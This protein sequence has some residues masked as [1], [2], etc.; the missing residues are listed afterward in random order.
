MPNPVVHFEIGC[1]DREKS[2]SFYQQLF[3]WQIT[4][5]GHSHDIRTDPENAT[6]QAISGHITSLGHEPY[7]YTNF[8]VAVANAAEYLAKAEALGG[9]TLIPPIKLPN[10]STFAWFTDIDGNTVGLLSRE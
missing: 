3:D 2:A 7:N 4:P 9:K 5:A 1:R 10:G 6:A 8:Y